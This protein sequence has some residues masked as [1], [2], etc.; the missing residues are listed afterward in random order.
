MSSIGTP[1]LDYATYN[2]IPTYTP[3]DDWL[4]FL[5]ITNAGAVLEDNSG[6]C[7]DTTGPLEHTDTI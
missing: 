1:I 6:N 4:G 5:L 2:P 7:I 3:P